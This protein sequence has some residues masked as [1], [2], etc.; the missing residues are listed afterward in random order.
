MKIKRIKQLRVNAYTFDVKWAKETGNSR[1]S[2]NE[3]LIEIGTKDCTEDEIFMF[4]C[5]ELFELCAIEMHV[6]LNRPDCTT[7][8]IFVFDHRQHDTL[9]NMFAGLLMQ[10]IV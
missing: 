4:I 9:N 8:Y 6:H 2:Y 7:D 1:T 10:F 5:H 3:H